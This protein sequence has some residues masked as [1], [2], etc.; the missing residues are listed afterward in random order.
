MLLVNPGSNPHV[1]YDHPDTVRSHI[2]FLAKA[3]PETLAEIANGLLADLE[4]ARR[5]PAGNEGSD[6]SPPARLRDLAEW[7][8]SL[9][10][11]TGPGTI[12]RRSV[13]LTRIIERAR[14][15]LGQKG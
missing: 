14:E 12:D 9:D 13:T 3:D 8:V 15:A 7:L 1:V 4:N 2:A 10:D 11:L 6:D 5:G